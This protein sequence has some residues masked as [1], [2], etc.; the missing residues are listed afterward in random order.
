MQRIALSWVLAQ[1]VWKQ[2]F[3]SGSD[4]RR[5]NTVDH[6]HLDAAGVQ[7]ACKSLCS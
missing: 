3:L 1:L 7:S 2:L 6:C 5:L 4:C